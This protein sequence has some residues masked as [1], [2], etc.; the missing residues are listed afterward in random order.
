MV[1][2]PVG[3]MLVSL[4]RYSTR[5]LGIEVDALRQEVDVLKRLSKGIRILKE[6]LKEN[7]PRLLEGMDTGVCSS[8]EILS[9]LN[10]ASRKILKDPTEF[11]DTTK[12]GQIDFALKSLGGSIA[13]TRDT[14][15]YN[16]SQLE[17]LY[18]PAEQILQPC[19][20]P[21]EC[22]AFE[23]SGAVVIRL[24]GKV[25]IRAVSM[26]HVSRDTLAAGLRKSAPK[27]F[28]VWGLDSLHEEGHFLGNFTYDID[29]SPL[30]YFPVQEALAKS[31]P[32]IEL[33][34]HTNHGNPVYTC[35]YRF[36]V[37]GTMD[38]Y[39]RHQTEGQ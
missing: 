29:G 22:W 26:E 11:Y 8:S 6:E 17:T 38:H 24:I 4:C 23:G 39:G 33:K 21:G 35:L 30:Q 34:I 20:M 2:G 25:S 28:S 3:V 1:A 13:S 31:F 16:P 32:L 14:K 9:N 19:V 15:D 7:L 10:D 18:H 5:D 12:T 36:R 27:D 37:H